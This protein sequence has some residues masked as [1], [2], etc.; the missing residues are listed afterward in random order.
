MIGAIFLAILEKL[1]ALKFKFD[2]REKLN[3]N[4]I[5][6]GIYGSK[7]L[8]QTF[9]SVLVRRLSE[10]VDGVWNWVAEYNA[11]NFS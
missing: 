2:Y 8:G 4:Q 5:K 7:G 6:F 1:P 3:L 10:I 11:R 9:L